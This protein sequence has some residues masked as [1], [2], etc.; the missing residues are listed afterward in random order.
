MS[1]KAKITHVPAVRSVFPRSLESAESEKSLIVPVILNATAAT[2]TKWIA[3]WFVITAR[4]VFSY[5]KPAIRSL[6]MF[7]LVFFLV[8]Y[9]RYDMTAT[10]LSAWRLEVE[11]K[12]PV[13][14]T[15]KSTR[16]A[17]N[18]SRFPAME[19]DPASAAR[20]A[21]ATT[22]TEDKRDVYQ[23]EEICK[24][25]WFTNAPR[26]KIVRKTWTELNRDIVRQRNNNAKG[27]KRIV[28]TTAA[29]RDWIPRR[30]A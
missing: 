2:M 28:K 25:D 20:I 21:N 15:P 11:N 29:A 23:H 7:D 19:L 26:Q 24:E 18:K 5:R 8:Y 12:R 6:L 27:A 10:Y 4:M 14:P 1:V 3:L 16:S 30:E 9:D 13:K 22:R 17:I